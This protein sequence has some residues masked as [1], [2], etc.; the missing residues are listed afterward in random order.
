MVFVPSR[1]IFA[2]LNYIAYTIQKNCE[3]LLAFIKSN[4][5][6]S[7]SQ[8]VAIMQPAVECGWMEQWIFVYT[9]VH[10]EITDKVGGLTL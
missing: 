3:Y 8:R 1:Y 7:D 5:I 4:Y 6:R 10:I 9:L 2:V